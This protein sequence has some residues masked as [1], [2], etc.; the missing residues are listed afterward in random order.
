MFYYAEDDV[1][2][3]V[4]GRGFVNPRKRKS[5]HSQMFFKTGALKNL[6]NFTGKRPCAD[7]YLIKLQA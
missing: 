1:F 2:T 6:E 4:K 7:R 3:K 5:S